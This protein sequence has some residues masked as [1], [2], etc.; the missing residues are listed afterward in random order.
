MD[1]VGGC[2][3]SKFETVTDIYFKKIA[4]QQY[5][6]KKKVIQRQKAAVSNTFEPASIIQE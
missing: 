2:W 4:V 5:M 1:N 6:K 3:C